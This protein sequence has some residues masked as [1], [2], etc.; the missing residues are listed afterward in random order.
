MPNIIGIANQIG[1]ASTFGLGTPG[2]LG[3]SLKTNGTSTYTDGA[4][5]FTASDK[6]YLSI[7][8][9]SQTGL[10]PLTGDYSY[11]FWVNPTTLVALGILIDKMASSGLIGNILYHS[12]NGS[13]TVGMGDGTSATAISAAGVLTTGT[14]TNL[15]VVAN[16]AGNLYIYKNGNT[17]SPVLTVDISARTGSIDSAS[18]FSVGGYAAVKDRVFNGSMDSLGFWNK[19][20]S[21]AE[22]TSLYNAGAGKIYTDLT[23]AEKVSMVSW[24]GFNE[25]GGTRYDAHGTNHLSQVFTN[26]IDNTST[27]G[28]ELVTNGTFSDVFTEKILNGGFVNIDNW[29]AVNSNLNSVGGGLSG[30]CLEVTNDGTFYGFAHQSFTTVVG[31][32]YSVTYSFKKGTGALGNLAIGTGPGG[33]TIYSGPYINDATWTTRTFTFTATGTT[34]YLSLINATNVDHE[35]ALWD[36]IS[37]TMSGWTA[38]NATLASV[39]GGQSG[40][41]LEVTNV[42]TSYGLASQMVTTVVNQN[43]TLSFYYKN[44]T[45]SSANYGVAATAVGIGIIASGSGLSSAGAWALKTINFKATSTTTFLWFQVVPNTDTYTM[46]F[47]TI[48]LKALTQTNLNGGFESIGTGE[49]LGGE[50]LSNPGF[51]TAGGGGADVFGTWAEVTTAGTVEDETTIVK[52][53]SH[54]AKLTASNTSSAAWVQNTITGLTAGARYKLT[55]WTR[56]DGTNAGQYRLYDNIN[57]AAILANTSTGITGTTYTQVTQYFTTPALCTAVIVYCVIPPATG[58]IAYF[59]DVSLKQVTTYA[60]FLNW[61]TVPAA[62]I[63]TINVET[64]AP[65]AGTYA[66]RLDNDA[67]GSLTYVQGGGLTASHKYKLTEYVKTNSGTTSFY[68][69]GSSGAITLTATTSYALATVYFTSPSTVFY[70]GYFNTASKSLY[71]DDVTLI[72]TEI[73]SA[74]GIAAGLAIDGNLCASFNGTTQ[75]LSVASNTSVQSGNGSTDFEIGCW[76]NFASFPAVVGQVMGK[77]STYDSSTIGYSLHYIGGLVFSVG[78]GSN[79][80]NT[81][82]QALNVNTWYFVRGWINSATQTI[83]IS[84]NNGTAVSTSIAGFT[85]ADINTAFTIGAFTNNY[86]ANARVDGAYLIKRLLTV[87]ESTALYN[88]GK[89]VK[90]A[91]LPSTV[92]ADSSLSFWNLDE[93]SAGTGNVTRNDSTALGNNLTSAGNTPSGQGVNYYEGTVSKWLDQSGKSANFIQATQS[94]RLLYVTNAQNGRPALVGDGLTKS[95]YNATDLIGTGDVTVFCVVNPRGWG[96]AN[97]GRILYN[98]QFALRVNATNAC[99]NVSSDNLSTSA[100]TANSSITL[101]TPYVVIVTRTSAGVTNIFLNGTKSGTDDQSSGTPA[102]GTNTIIGNSALSTGTAGFDGSIFEVGI[103]N[104]IL[105]ASEITRVSNYLKTK[106]AI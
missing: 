70:A 99:L 20:L 2:S 5:Q 102:G 14:W 49:T 94:A 63:S 72:C 34:T 43:Y 42:G 96:G 106:Y 23:T 84:I 27:L 21:A 8:D 1:S 89:G 79:I 18:A 90:Y 62:G 71:I 10:D 22:V 75:Y 92:S 86:F 58:G 98:G 19:A 37:V 76:I 46:L 36:S 35:T 41:A 101:E 80:R 48:S 54:A 40:N 15:T 91:G 61:T 50:L 39:A 31:G 17:A 55:F 33:A 65:Y 51:E 66:V 105:S 28:T 100:V 88:N 69:G 85:I 60:P 87:S 47:D 67:T 26:I 9:A 29:T 53:G 64:T 57:A 24:W 81:A 83:N 38:T 45:G 30:N 73:P 77:S 52:S 25:E 104:K 93:Y 32:V 4:I 95:L 13:I 6:A 97:V 7:A 11:S 16:R 56:G 103:Y 74:A 68:A 59:D 82:A 78:S 12:A 3:L 44:G